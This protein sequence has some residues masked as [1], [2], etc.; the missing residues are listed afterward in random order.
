MSKIFPH[1]GD[2]FYSLD[3]SFVAAELLDVAACLLL[4]VDARCALCSAPPL[5]IA[6]NVFHRSRP[7]ADAD[8][9]S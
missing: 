3:C 4:Y 7:F 1:S 8:T 6:M 2:M 5:Q 9:I